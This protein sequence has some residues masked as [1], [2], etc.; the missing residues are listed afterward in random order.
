MALMVGFFFQRYCCVVKLCCR[1]GHIFNFKK[2][3]LWCCGFSGCLLKLMWCEIVFHDIW[4]GWCSIVKLWYL[5]GLCL[6]RKMLTFLSGDFCMACAWI[7]KMLYCE[8]VKKKMKLYFKLV[9]LI[10]FSM[11]LWLSLYYQC[12]YWCQFLQL[13]VLVSASPSNGIHDIGTVHWLALLYSVS[14][15]QAIHPFIAHSKIIIYFWLK[16]EMIHIKCIQIYIINIHSCLWENKPEYNSAN[17]KV[18]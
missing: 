5:S 16:T 12:D 1:F 9:F 4:I 6:N 11:H 17:E 10:L 8:A 7:K 3:G 15:G 14:A 13:K 2:C 18:W